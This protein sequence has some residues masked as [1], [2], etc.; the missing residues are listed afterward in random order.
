MSSEH[1]NINPIGRQSWVGDERWEIHNEHTVLRWKTF[2]ITPATT[3]DER[4]KAFLP[5]GYQ[6]TIEVEWLSVGGVAYKGSGHT[7]EDRR[8]MPV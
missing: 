4:K 5:Q 7:T 1:T 2:T 6:K 3:E 8:G